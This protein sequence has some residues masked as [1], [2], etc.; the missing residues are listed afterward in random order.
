MRYAVRVI[1]WLYT[2]FLTFVLLVKNP[3][4]WMPVQLE[5]EAVN[6]G[7]G[8]HL[9]PHVLT[10]LLLAVLAWACRWRRPWLVAVL[11]AAYA[12]GTEVLQN[13]TG[14]C[15]DP[16]DMLDNLMGLAWG[17]AGWFFVVGVRRLGRRKTRKTRDE[18][19]GNA[20]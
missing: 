17:S 13:F 15:M 6:D 10:F 19:G 2:A 18:N 4:D 16:W 12:V 8:L 1:F 9:S 5:E 14:R 20:E 7:F 11:L 3:F